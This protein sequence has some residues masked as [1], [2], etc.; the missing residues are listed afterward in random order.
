MF[1]SNQTNSSIT[2]KQL[3]LAKN[4]ANSNK[5]VVSFCRMIVYECK[6]VLDS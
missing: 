6:Q 1:N 4:K 5:V 3:F 2:Q